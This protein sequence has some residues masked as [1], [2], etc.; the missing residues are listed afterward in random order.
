MKHL[1]S[2]LLWNNHGWDQSSSHFWCFSS[3]LLVDWFILV[4]WLEPLEMDQWNRYNRWF[5]LTS[6]FLEMLASEQAPVRFV[7]VLLWELSYEVAQP[8]FTT[9]LTT[10]SVQMSPFLLEASAPL[11]A[12]NLE[13]EVHSLVPE[14]SKPSSQNGVADSPSTPLASLP[15]CNFIGYL[16]LSQ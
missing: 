15:S 6:S 16:G 13:T 1:K 5:S 3:L 14:A 2:F 7:V 11:S 8:I 4:W 10:L 9:T 12:M